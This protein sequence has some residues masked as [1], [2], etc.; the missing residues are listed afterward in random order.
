M[1][2][3]PGWH[4]APLSTITESYLKATEYGVARRKQPMRPLVFAIVGIAL[5]YG[6]PILCNWVE[7]LLK[8]TIQFILYIIGRYVL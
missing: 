5:G 3:H 6:Y 2:Y 4:Y 8:Q 7:F 1:K